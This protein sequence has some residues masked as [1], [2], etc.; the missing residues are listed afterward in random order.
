MLFDKGIKLKK[1][2]VRK[3]CVI[4]SLGNPIADLPNQFVSALK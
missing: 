2:M 3:M 4:F 1:F